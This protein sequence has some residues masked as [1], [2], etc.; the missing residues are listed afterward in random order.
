MKYRIIIGTST[1]YPY[2][3]QIKRSRFSFWKEISRNRSLEDAEVDLREYIKS[4]IPSP[5]TIVKIYEES[6]LLI[7]KLKGTM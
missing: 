3:V 2:K 1:S 5:G 4:N 7:D 6:D